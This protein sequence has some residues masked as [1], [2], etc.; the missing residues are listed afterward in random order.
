VPRSKAYGDQ[1]TRTHRLLPLSPRQ[2]EH[3]RLIKEQAV[4]DTR[5]VELDSAGA[6]KRER[7]NIHSFNKTLVYATRLVSSIGVS[8]T[9]ERELLTSA[10]HQQTPNKSGRDLRADTDHGI[11]EIGRDLSQ[12]GGVVVVRNGLYDG[13]CSLSW[14]SREDYHEHTSWIFV[15]NQTH[16]YQIRQ[17]H[18]HIRAASSKRHQRG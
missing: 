4:S 12:D 15:I 16:R 2:G 10:T 13:S 5:T 14:V 8:S 6:C 9:L 18:H 7:N 17:R 11:S 3:G 1:E